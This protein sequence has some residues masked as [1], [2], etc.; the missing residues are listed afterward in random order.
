MAL[1]GDIFIQMSFIII[2][3]LDCSIYETIGHPVCIIK[4]EHIVRF[5]AIIKY[6][7]LNCHLNNIM[8]HF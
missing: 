8:L 3:K 1:L 6:T 5:L 4:I 2:D 7:A